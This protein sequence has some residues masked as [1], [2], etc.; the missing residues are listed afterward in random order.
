V[1]LLPIYLIDGSGLKGKPPDAPDEKV[2]SNGKAAVADEPTN[3]SDS[4]SAAEAE[5]DGAHKALEAQDDNPYASH[6]RP[7]AI[8]WNKYLEESEAEDKELTEIWDKNLDSLLIFVSNVDEAP[9]TRE[10]ILVWYPAGRI[11]R[12]DL[13]RIPD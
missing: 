12:R 8:I 2:T 3:I 4:K 11:V 5:T 10:L 13:D 6:C 9:E 7:D 1:H